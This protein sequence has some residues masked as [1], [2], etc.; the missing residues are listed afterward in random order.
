LLG[1]GIYDVQLK[2]FGKNRTLTS[3]RSFRWFQVQSFV[4]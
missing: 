1:K 2:Y 3:S 4:K